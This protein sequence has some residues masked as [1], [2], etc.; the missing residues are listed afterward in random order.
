M[1]ALFAKNQLGFDIKQAGYF[2]ALVGLLGVIWRGGLIGPIVKRFGEHKSLMIG[3]VAS[4]A[5]LILHRGR[6]R[7]VEIDLR[8]DPL[9]VRA[10]RLAP[11]ADQP[12]RACRPAQ[13]ARR[14]LRL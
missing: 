12:H 5:G 13:P 10:Q 8:G 2:L 11:V 9:L 4:A 14:R 3:L 6:G 1:F 7:L